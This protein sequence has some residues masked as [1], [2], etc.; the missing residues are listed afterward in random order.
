MLAA[1]LGSCLESRTCHSLDRLDGALYRNGGW[2]P[3]GAASGRNERAQVAVG[4]GVSSEE[5]GK[6]YT[7]TMPTKTSSAWNALLE[8]TCPAQRDQ[9]ARPFTPPFPQ[10]SKPDHQDAPTR[11]LWQSMARGDIPGV[12]QAL[13]DGADLDPC[14]T[15]HLGVQDPL[16]AALSCKKWELATILF[17]RGARTMHSGLPAQF[18]SDDDLEG[19][20]RL[21]DY[22]VWSHQAPLQV[23]ARAP[24]VLEWWLTQNPRR[25]KQ[26]PRLH[27]GSRE[28]SN[29][30]QTGL[31]GSAQLRQLITSAWGMHHGGVNEAIAHDDTLRKFW[32][33]SVWREMIEQKD[34]PVFMRNAV[35]AGWG[36]PE[37]FPDGPWGPSLH[38][39]W[40]LHEWMMRVPETQAVML[41]LAA[42]DPAQTWWK[43]AAKMPHHMERLLGEGFEPLAP[44]KDGQTL[45]HYIM[46]QARALDGFAIQWAVA[47]YAHETLHEKDHAGRAAID[48][49]APTLRGKFEGEL[50]A[51]LEYE[52]MDQ[53]I[54]AAGAPSRRGPRL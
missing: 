22:G 38:N 19:F 26:L 28:L 23:V 33:E 13:A 34:D 25:W 32:S 2:A 48:M 14:A 54:Q 9:A 49:L 50:R 45:L 40:T 44:N 4:V 43:S 24:R 27:E 51:R 6:P 8:G 21:S 16:S 10:P 11:A 15:D 41:E 3:G 46:Q 12:R 31:K 29:L 47:N 7:E 30:I 42:Q 35:E 52:Q 37:L 39:A 36:T 20:L 17:D 5:Q 53:T 18:A 1:V